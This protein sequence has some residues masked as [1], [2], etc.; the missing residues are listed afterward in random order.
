[1]SQ[2]LLP[3]SLRV[4][5]VLAGIFG[6][7]PASADPLRFCCREDNDLFQAATE[8]GI[9]TIR[10][11]SPRDT[12]AG[13]AAG[14]GLLVLADGYPGQTTAIDNH[15]F[16]VAAKKR[17]RLYVKYPATLPGIDVGTPRGTPRG[18][19]WERAVVA[20]DL[21]APDIN[22]LAILAIHDCRFV[23]VAAAQ[24]HRVAGFDRAGDGLPK[25]V[26]Q[27]LFDLPSEEGPG[28]IANDLLP[29]VLSRNV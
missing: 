13:A 12:F 17:L 24:P 1:M 7:Y 21:F 8:S 6:A 9:D 28:N 18:T 20:S 26:F 4:F 10:V 2:R 25:P 19:H 27:I 23:P 29:P 11:D 22:P 5:A 14:S 16:A 15:F 3:A